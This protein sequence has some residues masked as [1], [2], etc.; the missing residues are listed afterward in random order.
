MTPILLLKGVIQQ[1]FITWINIC[2]WKLEL[3]ISWPPRKALIFKNRALLFFP[4]YYSLRLFHN[5]SCQ[6]QLPTLIIELLSVR[7]T[8]P[9]MNKNWVKLWRREAPIALSFRGE[10]CRFIYV[11][12]PSQTSV[13][14]M[15]DSGILFSA[16]LSLFS[17]S[18]LATVN[19]AHT[20]S[21]I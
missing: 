17:P 14:Q 18:T 16:F 2:W 3:R 12:P 20:H 10:N 9:S 4:L 7:R 13:I 15:V 8:A 11:L 1:I 5:I 21:G 19:N 6:G